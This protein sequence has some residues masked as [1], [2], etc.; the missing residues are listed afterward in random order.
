MHDVRNNE[1]GYKPGEHGTSTSLVNMGSWDQYK[2]GGYGTSEHWTSTNMGPVQLQWI[3]DQYN[4]GGLGARTCIITYFINK[5]CK[6]K[7]SR[8]TT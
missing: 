5:N 4:S 1:Y 2:P 3:W 7:N 8:N 6:T